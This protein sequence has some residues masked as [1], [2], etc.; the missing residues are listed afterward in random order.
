MKIVLSGGHLTPALAMI[1]Y[2]KQHHPDTELFFVGRLY[3]R[4]DRSQVA[5]EKSEVTARSVTF[6]PFNTGKITLQS[7]VHIISNAW[8]L[9][10]GIASAITL[11]NSIKPHVFLSFGGYMAVPLA[12]AAWLHKI[13]IVTHEQTRDAGFANRLIGRF[14]KKVAV[15]F[16]TSNE[17]FSQEKVVHTGNPVR[18]AILSN[19]LTRPDWITQLAMKTYP[20]LYITGG[21]QGSE[22]LNAT[23]S[24]ALKD[25]I[26]DWT[27]IHSC[28]PATSKRNYQ[29][30]LLRK[31]STL[32]IASQSRYFVRE[33]CT[34]EELQWIYRNCQLM[35]SRA[36]AN[37]IQEIVLCSIPSVL[38][39]LPFSHAQEQEKNALELSQVGAA[40]IILQKD[41]TPQRLL[42]EV[43]LV[44]RQQKKMRIALNELATVY[45]RH[46]DEK[47]AALIFDVCKK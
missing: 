7:P 21:S 30:E 8:L 16:P 26:K 34:Q 5:P 46:A 36:G 15:T 2:L 20:I 32:S 28:G 1:D 39:P 10:K 43:L 37:T 17:Y 40:R 13:P 6:I 9:L 42:D 47:L 19:S 33:W 11:F 41:L 44:A 45:D 3:T 35:I 4:Q 12:I 27:I 31:R 38:I 24:E 14:A 18:P 25:L 23:V 29:N 22:I